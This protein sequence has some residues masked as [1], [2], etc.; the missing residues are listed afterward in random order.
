[1]W[2]SLSQSLCTDVSISLLRILYNIP[3]VVP[4]HQWLSL[5]QQMN[6]TQ[7]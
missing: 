3:E 4:T 2:L 1:M 6:H 5:T 7:T